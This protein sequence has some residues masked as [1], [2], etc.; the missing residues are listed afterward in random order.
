MYSHGLIAPVVVLVIWSL[1]M[2]IWLYAT[3][4]PAMSA[5]KIKPAS[6]TRAEFE[7]KMPAWATRPADNYNHLMEQPTL[8]YALCF[9]LQLLGEPSAYVIGLAWLYVGLRIVHSL[10]QAT[11]NIIM[12]RFLIFVA[13]S[14]VLGFLAVHAAMQMDIL[15]WFS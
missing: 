13:S 14:V 15:H 9:A 2:L 1:V 12:I 6:A 4:I 11:L 7:A 10:L 5:A 8:F 3:R